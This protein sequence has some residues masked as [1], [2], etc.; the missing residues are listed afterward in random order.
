MKRLFA[1]NERPIAWRFDF[2]LG[3]VLRFAAHSSPFDPSRMLPVQQV[4]IFC[5]TESDLGSS[6]QMECRFDSC[7]PY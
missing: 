7:H 2:D 6:S 5:C 3:D 1:S 4:G